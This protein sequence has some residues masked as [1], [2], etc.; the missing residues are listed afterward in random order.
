[1]RYIKIILFILFSLSAHAQPLL[2]GMVP[3]NGAIVFA[4]GSVYS[5]DG[6]DGLFKYSDTSTHYDDS[7]NYIKPTAVVG[8]GRW[9]RINKKVERFTVNGTSAIS[10]TADITNVDIDPGANTTLT[11]TAIRPEQIV[12]VKRI[13][14]TAYTV[15]VAM[16]SGTIDGSSNYTITISNQ[17]YDIVWDGTNAKIN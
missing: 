4:Y 13:D 14:N 7:M 11:I 1:M 12:N 2:K 17:S 6:I 10:L 8:A 15:T 5:G 16:A 3:T 9:I